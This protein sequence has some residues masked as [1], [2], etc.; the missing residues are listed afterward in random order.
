MKPTAASIALDGRLDELEWRD[1]P[2]LKLV[3]QSPRSGQPAPYETEVRVI[4]T[5]YWI[6]FGFVCRDPEPD[7]IAIHTMRRDDSMDGDDTVALVLD[8][9]GDGKTGY[10]FRVNAA[11]ARA[12]GLIAD[13]EHPS[14]DWDGIW[15]ARTVR[16]EDGWSAEI[17]I[18]SR[19]LSFSAGLK[20]WGLNAERTIPRDRTVMR[21]ASPTLDAFLYDLSRA[22]SLSGVEQLQQGRGLE[23]SPYSIGRM[24]NFFSSSPRAW[25]GAF[26][27]DFT[28]KITPQLVTVFTANT[29]F[30][31]TEADARQIN[32]TRF[33]LFFPEKR[34]F[35]LEG[36]NQYEFGLGLGGQ[37]IPFF[38]RRIGLLGGEQIPIDGGAKLNGRVG[39]WNLAMLDVQTRETATSAGIVPATNLMAGRISY[40]V[41]SKLRVGTIFTNGDPQGLRRKSLAGVD[42]VWRTSTF[43]GNKNLLV[44]GW[45]AMSSGDLQPGRR[46]GWGARV[47]YPNDFLDCAASVNDYGV[48]LNP[49]LGFLPR[50]GVRQTELRCTLQPRPSKTGV[51]R[52]VRQQFFENEFTLVKNHLGITESWNYFMAP[53]N[54]QLESGDRVEF[55]WNPQYE[56]LAAKFE[57]APGVII[58]PGSYRFTRWRVE[59]QTSTHRR[60]QAG[61]T[62]WFGSFYDGDLTQWEDYVKWTSS[63]GRLQF[64][65]S[66]ENDFGHLK[67]GNFVQRL[68][69]LQSAYAWSPNL[70][71]SS[72]IQYDT[73]SQNLGA[74][75]RLRWTLKPGN[76]L[77]VVWNRGWQKLILDPRELSLIP[78]NELLAVKLRWTFRQ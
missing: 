66:T 76:D 12:D 30:A 27:G 24:K 1:A 2:V 18:P 20:Q 35:F 67:Q 34:S 45:T 70:V 4:I 23:F 11:G 78:D 42:A 8:T 17:A 65:L 50:P 13:P 15:D 72:F 32:L 41:T 44:G 19:T 40:D 59:A 60:L 33:P 54:F 6:Y 61:S 64:G 48:A 62:T 52:A 57:I 3:Q 63:K 22:G 71:L 53:L 73:A 25:Q 36:A 69:Q 58:P 29:D 56:F 14:Y 51:F 16:T 37:F 7:R 77:F 9:Y 75:T 74:N 68:W 49:A 47:D 31:E 38:S 39:R 26:G 55:N 21:W 28:W 5:G 10:W 43:R 46:T